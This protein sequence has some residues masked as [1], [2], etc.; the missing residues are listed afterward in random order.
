MNRKLLIIGILLL[1]FFPGCTALYKQEVPEEPI[2]PELKWDLGSYVQ[3]VKQNMRLNE[4]NEIH[5]MVLPN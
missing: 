4:A 2:I 5:V 1:F 3:F